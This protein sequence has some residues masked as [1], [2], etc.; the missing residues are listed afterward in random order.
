[1]FVCH[2]CHNGGKCLDCGKFCTDCA[3]KFPSDTDL[4][5][6]QSD[7][8]DDDYWYDVMDLMDRDYLDDDYEDECDYD[9]DFDDMFNYYDEE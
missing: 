3:E 2:R 1:M 7:G 8:D 6:C 5:V 9:E 4:C